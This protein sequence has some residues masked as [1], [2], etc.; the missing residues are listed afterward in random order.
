MILIKMVQ[1]RSMTTTPRASMSVPCM[2]VPAASRMMTRSSVMA[3][4]AAVKRSRVA[5]FT[6]VPACAARA[7]YELRPRLQKTTITVT[8]PQTPYNLRPRIQVA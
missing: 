4:A 2:S 5:A 3:R 1:T 7:P 6:T 8:I